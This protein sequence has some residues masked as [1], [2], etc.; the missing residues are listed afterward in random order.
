MFFKSLS[1]KVDK[2]ITDTKAAET[3]AKVLEYLE[4]K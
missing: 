4:V 2:A 3:D 1:N